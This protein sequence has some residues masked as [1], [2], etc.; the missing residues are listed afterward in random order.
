MIRGVIKEKLQH[1]KDA[2]VVLANDLEMVEEV[3]VDDDDNVMTVNVTN[4][5]LV[6]RQITGGD[7]W[8]A[9]MARLDKDWASNRSIIHHNVSSGNRVIYLGDS[10]SDLPLL[11]KMK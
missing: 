5:R 10:T 9:T 6:E 1:W 7:K 11:G 3:V 2:V 8:K 4:G